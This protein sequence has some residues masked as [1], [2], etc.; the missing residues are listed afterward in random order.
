MLRAFCRA[1][2]CIWRAG[3]RPDLKIASRPLDREATDR[4]THAGEPFDRIYGKGSD[5]I[6]VAVA[7]PVEVMNSEPSGL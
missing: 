4:A 5:W 3:Y 7:V 2:L 6:R 1:G